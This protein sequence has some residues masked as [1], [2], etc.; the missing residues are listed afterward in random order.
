MPDEDAPIEVA[1]P[2]KPV[3]PGPKDAVTLVSKLGGK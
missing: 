2:P 1:E 3:G